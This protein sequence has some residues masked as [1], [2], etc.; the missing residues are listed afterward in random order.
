MVSLGNF[1]MNAKISE[2]I[3]IGSVSPNSSC[4]TAGL[5]V[6]NWY[7]YVALDLFVYSFK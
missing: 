4:W 5:E 2:N 6:Q 1:P 7:D 3:S